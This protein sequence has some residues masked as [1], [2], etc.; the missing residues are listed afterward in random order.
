[1]SAKLCDTFCCDPLLWTPLHFHSCLQSSLQWTSIEYTPTVLKAVSSEWAKLFAK[2]QQCGTQSIRISQSCPTKMKCSLVFNY[3]LLKLSSIWEGDLWFAVL[4]SQNRNF[5][6][7]HG[8]GPDWMACVPI[9]RIY[10]SWPH[11]IASWL[12]TCKAL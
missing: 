11:H 8:V 4:Y 1:M 2:M 7:G 9:P 3:P 5:S 10:V 12:S 6:W